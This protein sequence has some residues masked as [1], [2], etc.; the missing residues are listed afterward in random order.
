[1]G[2]LAALTA[3]E[4]GLFISGNDGLLN[5]AGLAGL[6]TIGSD[7][8]ISANRGLLSISGLANV[9]TLGGDRSITDNDALCQGDAQSVADALPVAGTVL[10]LGN[11]GVCK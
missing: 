4:G 10:V 5:L 9:T 7:L 3:V 1:M 6:T 11:D 8:N 2:A